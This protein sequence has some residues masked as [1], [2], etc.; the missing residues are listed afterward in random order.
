MVSVSSGE[1]DS[2]PTRGLDLG[3]FAV[4]AVLLMD[5]M[6][7]RGDV[8]LS[9]VFFSLATLLYMLDIRRRPRRLS[10]V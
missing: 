2:E 8:G 9:A 5:Y 10:F 6:L 1:V 3:R 7:I 4:V